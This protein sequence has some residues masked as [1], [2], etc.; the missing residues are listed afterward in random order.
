LLIRIEVITTIADR[1]LV[2]RL[3]A[4]EQEMELE[5]GVKW[6]VWNQ[7]VRVEG[8][9]RGGHEAGTDRILPTHFFPFFHI[10]HHLLPSP[11]SVVLVQTKMSFCIN[12][13]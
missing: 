1:N 7:V 2:C 10:V 6:R 9:N 12:E 5:N 13:A 11:T 4:L 8:K 3:P